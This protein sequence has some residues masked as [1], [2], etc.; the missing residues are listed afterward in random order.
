MFLVKRNRERE[1]EIQVLA[2]FEF[3]FHLPREAP[4]DKGVPVEKATLHQLLPVPN[5]LLRP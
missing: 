3:P 2:S 5:W 4:R 1:I